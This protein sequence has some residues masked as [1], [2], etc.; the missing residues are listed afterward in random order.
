M[1]P[2]AAHA[3]IKYR[4]K[5]PRKASS[6]VNPAGISK[7][8][9]WM[10]V[11]FPP[12]KQSRERPGPSAP[13]VPE[14]GAVRQRTAFFLL[15]SSVS[16]SE[17]SPFCKCFGRSQSSFAFVTHTETAR[18]FSSNLLSAVFL[19]GLGGFFRSAPRLL[20]PGKLRV[21][22]LCPK[23]ALFC[24]ISPGQRYTTGMNTLGALQKRLIQSAM[25]DPATKAT[26]YRYQ[27]RPFLLP[28]IFIRRFRFRRQR[29]RRYPPGRVM[30]QEF[31]F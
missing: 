10:P 11:Y 27:D 8:K 30:P 28:K 7:V 31:V 20:S 16:T 3:V 1:A 2:R 18:S 25:G 19:K 24:R 14:I 4:V 21:L 15:Q 5:V 22:L 17:F 9:L 6:M 23:W 29:S 13:S 12:K 26:T